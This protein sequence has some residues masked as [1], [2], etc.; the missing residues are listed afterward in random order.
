M[1]AQDVRGAVLNWSRSG[2]TE[3]HGFRFAPRR[4]TAYPI[5]SHAAGTSGVMAKAKRQSGPD[6]CAL[7]A[8]GASAGG[9]EALRKLEAAKTGKFHLAV[10]A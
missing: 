9:I 2:P 10:V 3:T 5:R 4:L 7:V 6:P 1:R 8:I